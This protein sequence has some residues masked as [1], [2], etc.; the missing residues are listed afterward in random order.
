[1]EIQIFNFKFKSFEESLKF[2]NNIKWYVHSSKY[3]EIYQENCSLLFTC[4]RYSHMFFVAELSLIVDKYRILKKYN[5]IQIQYL[6]K[7][8]IVSKLYGNE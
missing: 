3:Y 5:N 7:L 6:Y 2:D 8:F 1:M 4:S